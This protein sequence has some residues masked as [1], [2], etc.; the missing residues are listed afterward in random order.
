MIRVWLTGLLRRQRA[1]LLGAAVGVAVAVA[2]IATLGSFLATSQATM[3][4]RAVRSVAVDWQVQLNPGADTIAASRLITAVPGVAAVAPV[5]FAHTNGLSA[6]VGGSSQTTGPG[7]VLGIPAT[8]R[9]LFPQQFRTLTGADSGVLLAQQTAAN[10]H[11]APGDMIS[12]GRDGLPPVAVRVAGIVEL[13]QAN[14]LFQ[15]VGAPPT[16]QPAAPPDNVVLLPE[17][18]W[19]NVFDAMAVNRPDLISTQVHLRRDHRLPPDPAVAYSAVRGAAHNL[20]ARSAGA[21]LVGDN[22]GA[23]LDAARGDAAYA[24]VLFLFLG[25]PGAV[26]AALLTSTVTAAGAGRRRAE[27]A[28]LRVRGATA[29]QLLVLATAE[30]AI[31]GAAGALAGVLGA[32]VVN[33]LAFGSPRFGTTTTA[34]LGWPAAAAA[35]GMAVAAATVLL[36]VWRELRGRT[37]AD[38]RRRHGSS[39]LPT[40]ARLGVDGLILAGAVLVFYAT[41]GSGY[42]LVLAPEGVPAISVSY[43]AFAGP[44]L[45]WIGAGLLTWRL[46]DLLLGRGHRLIAVVLRPFTAEL[47]GTVGAGLSRARRPLVRGIVLLTLAVAFAA[48]TATFNAT[49]RQ[50]AEVD[51]QLTNGADVTVTTTTPLPAEVTARFAAI[52][53]V[54]AVEPMAHRFAYIGA[55]LQDLYAVHP[56]SFTRATA[57]Q[58]G[59]FPQSDAATRMSALTHA[60]DSIL[61]SAETVHDFQ[62]QPGDPVTLRLVDASTKQPRPI[63][64]HY[65]G[66]VTEFPTAPK[67]SFLVANADYLATQTGA[68]TPNVYL[69]DTG[70]RDTAAVAARVRAVVGAG[71]TVT[72]IASV[73]AQVGSSLTAVDLSG[74]TR[75]ELSFALVLAIGAGALVLGL[76]LADRRRSYALMVALGARSRHLRALVFSET[77]VLTAAGILAGGVTGSVLSLM[78]VKVLRGVFDPPPDTVAVPWLYL[79]ATAAVTTGALGAVA[80]VAVVLFTRRPAQ[81]LIRDQ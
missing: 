11:A 14:S 30:A 50:Q 27:Q 16:A 9:Q 64:F 20:E 52:P 37:V 32:A 65:A 41:T 40:W 61:L 31:I 18:E 56:A 54:R 67:D 63:S 69:I 2:L 23:A 66:V 57:L 73:R 26:L 53:G 46:A 70:G 44:A 47:A 55:D 22:L 81:T 25:L 21:V 45:L 74:L 10:L 78:L 51:A 76:G 68:A 29:R 15:T 33:T 1:R 6:I 43:W 72:D 77:S 34:A 58:N 28:L 71:A 48:S 8:Y 62:L 38:A 5:G 36:P 17:R 39:S 80:A 59:Y 35:T 75:I 19:H 60:P 13:P 3:T 79:S 7:M 12:I 4:E 24:R 42:Q 49:Y